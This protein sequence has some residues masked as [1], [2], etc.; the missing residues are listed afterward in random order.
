[1]LALGGAQSMTYCAVM[2]FRTLSSV[3]AS[4]F[5]KQPC[6]ASHLR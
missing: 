2:R 3:G 6:G 5:R 4:V 1:M